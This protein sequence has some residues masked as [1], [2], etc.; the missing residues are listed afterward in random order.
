MNQ[1]L[2]A[3]NV[4]IGS[5]DTK[6]NECA[7]YQLEQIKKQQGSKFN[8]NKSYYLARAT[9]GSGANAQEAIY[10]SVKEMV[11]KN[12]KP[13]TQ[14]NEMIKTVMNSIG[15]DVMRF[16][17]KEADSVYLGGFTY[18]NT[19]KIHDK[20]FENAESFQNSFNGGVPFT[21]GANMT[22]LRV[23]MPMATSFDLLGNYDLGSP[24][25]N[26]LFGASEVLTTLSYDGS[27]S[28]IT[29]GATTL[30]QSSY[31]G[32]QHILNYKVAGIGITE[33][34]AII[35][36]FNTGYA[37][38][39]ILMSNL[40]RAI[41]IAE[42]KIKV[43]IMRDFYNTLAAD[44]ENVKTIK[45]SDIDSS[46]NTT[47]TKLLST[48]SGAGE[49]ATKVI[50][51]LIAPSNSYLE[52]N[53]R[54]L[55]RAVIHTSMNAVWKSFLTYALSGGT[56]GQTWAGDLR[57]DS[58]MK[59]LKTFY[60]GDIVDVDAPSDID[61]RMLFIAD[62]DIEGMKDSEYGSLMTVI[63]LAP[64]IMA[65]YGGIGFT[66]QVMVSKYSLPKVLIPKGA[67]FVV[68]EK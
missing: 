32:E 38:D 49:F 26:S 4:V 39:N 63:A 1:N 50:R 47:L 11:C 45:M 14:E 21:F 19:K 33:P 35:S 7:Y 43:Q 65:T 56:T 62:P 5:S 31:K 67:V 48:A 34:T 64:T 40:A 28:N 44:T 27:V 52:T 15:E 9:G 6:F 3:L 17:I 42:A 25:G 61:L 16:Q 12:E 23:Q 2:Q 66:N 8:P 57:L 10:N 60:G 13:D 20:V 36:G 22:N 18:N 54:S 51:G 58:T 59:N 29:N 68:G 24:T 41:K 46:L 53:Q 37:G 55:S 30:G